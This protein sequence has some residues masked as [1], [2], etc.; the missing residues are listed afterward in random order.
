MSKKQASTY[1]PCKAC[2]AKAEMEDWV[3]VQAFHLAH[4]FANKY[5][6]TGFTAP[7]INKLLADLNRI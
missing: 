6:H 3:P 5:G 7:Q 1:R 2:D 4:D